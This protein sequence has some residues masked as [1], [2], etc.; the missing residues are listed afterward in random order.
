MP[1][2]LK[3]NRLQSTII[4]AILIWSGSSMAKNAGDNNLIL[5]VGLTMAGLGSLCALVSILIN[6]KVEHYESIIKTLQLELKDA[7]QHAIKMGKEAERV[8]VAGR[9]LFEGH[10]LSSSDQGPSTTKTDVA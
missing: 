9:T 6:L 1:D 7:R 8:T 10:L 3:G 2:W 5:G 4:I